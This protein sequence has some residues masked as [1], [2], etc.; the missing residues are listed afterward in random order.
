MY[1]LIKTHCGIGVFKNPVGVAYIWQ[2]V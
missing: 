2:C 1:Q